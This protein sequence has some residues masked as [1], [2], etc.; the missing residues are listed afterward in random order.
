MRE[1]LLR[2]IRPLK[3]VIEDFGPVE[4]EGL[5]VLIGVPMREVLLWLIRLLEVLVDDF[6]VV[7]TDGF[8]A[9]I[10]L[11]IR[12]VLLWLIRLRV[13][14][15]GGFLTLEPEFSNI[16]PLKELLEDL[17]ELEAFEG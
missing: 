3:L 8:L 10:G 16:L 9:L 13:L 17:R 4:T 6:G 12:E 7:E 2:L 14:A 1:V 5:L 11:P 15:V